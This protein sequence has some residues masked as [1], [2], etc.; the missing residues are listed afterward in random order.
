MSMNNLGRQDAETEVFLDKIIEMN[1]GCNDN[2]LLIILSKIKDDEEK[3]Y[4]F[5]TFSINSLKFI[6][7]IRTNFAFNLFERHM[8]MNINNLS[9][10]FVA[11]ILKLI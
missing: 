6:F 2:A 1:G 7:V 5:K 11:K 8:N 4:L 9:K 3:V 10:V